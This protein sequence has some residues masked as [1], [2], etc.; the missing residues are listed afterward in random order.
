MA[1]ALMAWLRWLFRRLVGNRHTV[2]SLERIDETTEAEIDVL[3]IRPEDLPTVPALSTPRR[4]LTDRPW[5]V[6]A[7]SRSLT[8]FEVDQAAK[9]YQPSTVPPPPRPRGRK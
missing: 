4:T 1:R 6:P 8:D 5:Q 7:T 2:P 9:R 3:V